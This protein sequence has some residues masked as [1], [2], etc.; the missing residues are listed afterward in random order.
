MTTPPFTASPEMLKDFEGK[1]NQE[2][3]DEL[4]KNIPPESE[5]PADWP[6]EIRAEA[7]L[8]QA[9]QNKIADFIERGEEFAHRDEN[10]E[11]GYSVP[12]FFEALQQVAK[13][14]GHESGLPLPSLNH[15]DRQ[16]VT[17]RRGPLYFGR[18]QFEEELSAD[19]IDRA[20]LSLA[21]QTRIHN[22]WNMLGD[23]EVCIVDA[24]PELG[25]IA[26]QSPH[27]GNRL[28]KIM[29]AVGLRHGMAIDAETEFRA[30]DSLKKR[31]NRGQWNTYVLCGAF[32]ERSPRSDIHYVFRK[33]LPT[34]AVSFHGNKLRD[35]IDQGDDKGGRVLCALCLH[36]VGYFQGSHVGLMTPTD[37]VI[38]H[39]LM[40]RGDEHRYWGSCGQWS[41]IDPRAGV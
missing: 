38:T 28:R 17:A 23:K 27:A 11:V 14:H 8:R 30:M 13:E 19:Y 39:L 21:L 16:L 2:I 20:P 15:M 26:L 36:P 29:D 3:A 22:S 37:E 7:R 6:E 33:G 35:S 41:C 31:I 10:G 1:T 40:M 25:I 9:L 24:G 4:R 5:W 18:T 32:L 34:L 12:E